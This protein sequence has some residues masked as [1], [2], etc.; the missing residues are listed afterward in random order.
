MARELLAGTLISIHNLHALVQLVKDA[1]AMIV[2]GTF[3][4]AAPSLLERWK[5]NAQKS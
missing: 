1:R 5:N 3:Q 2:G 4:S